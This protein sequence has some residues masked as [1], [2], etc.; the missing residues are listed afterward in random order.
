MAATAAVHWASGST[1]RAVECSVSALYEVTGTP[2]NMA[3][4][5]WWSSWLLKYRQQIDDDNGVPALV[6]LTAHKRY[7]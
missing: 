6:A 2:V 3:A 4:V 1:R 5:A 7:P